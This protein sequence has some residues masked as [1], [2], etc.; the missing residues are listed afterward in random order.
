[1]VKRVGALK[2]GLPAHPSSDL[3]AITHAAQYQKV[4][5]YIESGQAEGAR[6]LVGGDKPSE[7]ELAGGFF[8]NPAVFDQ[9]RPEMAIAQEEI[10]GP[11]ISVLGW[12]DDDEMIEIANGTLYGLT[13][14]VLTNDLNK[15][16]RTA[17]AMDAGYVE[18]N[19]AVSF[20]AGS[21]FGGVKQSGLGREGTI[22]D[23]LSYTQVK[24]ININLPA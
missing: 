8:V 1:L 22:D 19:G 24:S 13:S 9:V 15:A 21:P 17:N 14:V 18:V 2:A 3:G 12:S 5:G 7:P 11:V 16:I 6:L 23:L 10:F 20:A 4:L